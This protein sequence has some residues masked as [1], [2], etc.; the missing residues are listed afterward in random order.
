MKKRYIAWCGTGWPRDWEIEHTN[1]LG[2]VWP[3]VDEKTC[4]PINGFPK[5]EQWCCV[6]FGDPVLQEEIC[7]LLNAQEE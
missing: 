2:V 7:H 4:G 5:P 6:V 3:I 1:K